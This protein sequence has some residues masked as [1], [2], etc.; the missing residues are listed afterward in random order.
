MINWNYYPKNTRIPD[1][2]NQIIKVFEKYQD[3]IDSSIY[4]LASNKVLKRITNDIVGLGF[5]LVSSSVR[6]F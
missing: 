4:Q 1:H 3:K 6:N 5:K 2:L